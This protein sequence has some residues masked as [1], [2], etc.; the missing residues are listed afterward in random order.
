MRLLS[1]KLISLYAGRCPLPSLRRPRGFTPRAA[2][3]E[4]AAAQKPGGGKKKKE[5]ELDHIPLLLEDLANPDKVVIAQTAPAVRVSIGE[6]VGMEPG[7]IATGQLVAALK[8]LGFDYVYDTLV[9][10]DLTIMEEGFELMGR[11][12]GKL[13][14]K[15]DS[16]PLPMFTSCCPGWINF[17]E[18][19]APEFIPHVSSCKS[20]HMMIGALLKNYYSRQLGKE[21][22][23]VVVTSIMP[24]V[25]KQGEADRI[26]YHTEGGVRDVD[27]VVNTRQLG[28]LVRTKGIDFKALPEKPYDEFMDI[29]TGAAAIFGTTGGVMEAALRTVYEVVTGEPLGALPL[30]EVR[31][32]EGVKEATVPIKPNPQGPLHNAQPLEVHVAVAHGLQ[33][34]K[35]VL[36]EVQ[37][38]RKQYEFVE[39]MACPGGCIGGGGQPRSKDRDI[40]KKRQAALYDV[41]ERATLRRSHENPI[42]Q[43]LYEAILGEPLSHES[44]RLLHTHYVE[45]GPPKFDYMKAK[46]EAARKEREVETCVDQESAAPHCLLHPE[47][48][49]EEGQVQGQAAGTGA[50]GEGEREPQVNW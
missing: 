17:V 40:L 3:V 4:E 16:A 27:H 32:L 35:K 12:K 41:D 45:G 9:G 22:K 18:T 19:C 38:G 28:E 49:R 47:L 6:E 44:H 24:C 8:E 29:G 23:D 1:P 14:G 31:G 36:D 10:A 13:E 48:G 15:A 5:Q 37:A 21:P 7:S 50:A 42:V 39:V 2:A 26:F 30:Q 20:P 43:H 46:E 11:L 33:N 25:R 34:A